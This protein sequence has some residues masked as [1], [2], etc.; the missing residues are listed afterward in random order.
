M[1]ET[2]TLR[3]IAYRLP[4][5]AS[6]VRLGVH[7]GRMT[8]GEQRFR[9]IV[10]FMEQPDPRRIAFRQTITDTFETTYVRRFEKGL[11][12]NV[13]AFVD[14][15]RSM[16][17]VGRCDKSKLAARLARALSECVLRAH[18]RFG[19]VAFSNRVDQHLFLP[20][21]R[22]RGAVADVLNK[23]QDR[24][25]DQAA[26]MAGV[27]EAA[28]L[29][30]SNRKLIFLISDFHWR[31]DDVH[32]CVESLRAHD[33]IPVILDDSA[34]HSDIP[35]WGFMRLADLETG[36]TKMLLMRPSL[37]SA[38][39]ERHNARLDVI[40]TQ[41]AQLGRKPMHLEDG[42]DWRAVASYLMQGG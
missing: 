2:T 32:K 19:I 29:I 21:T 9:D 1:T 17:F 23:L 41:F 38:I 25:L 35:D 8:G 12:V 20:A 18:D 7:R 28:G 3:D 42:I 33:V 6:G 4:W 30:G 22:A 11:S 24:K 40:A 27:E 36:R 14:I 26:G 16:S 13:Y 10:P 34:A 31:E 39:A 5:R 15:S 37:K